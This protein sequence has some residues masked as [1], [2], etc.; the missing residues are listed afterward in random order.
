VDFERG[1]R[2]G[3]YVASRNTIA[4]TAR[5]EDVNRQ[6]FLKCLFLEVRGGFLTGWQ[7]GVYV[8]GRNT[9]APTARLKN[10]NYQYFFEMSIFK[11]LGWV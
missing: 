3:V 7:L 5:W 8:A 6:Y 9:H 4:P 2:L 1:R 11:R 10:V